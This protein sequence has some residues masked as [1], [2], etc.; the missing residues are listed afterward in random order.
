MSSFVIVDNDLMQFEPA[1]GIYTVT[2]T[3]LCQIKASGIAKIL[4]KKVC[5]L[6]DE[7]KVSIKASYISSAFPTPG[8]GSIT[9]TS[10]AAD[11]QASF[12]TSTTALIVKGTQF[13]ALF[14]PETPA[15]NPQGPEPAPSPQPG[16]GSFQ[17]TQSFVTTG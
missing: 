16:K 10:L 1:F 6:G 7:K 14:T 12:A 5:I 9:I 11:Q 17:N 13:V 8:T 3:G 15:S 4:N 2:P